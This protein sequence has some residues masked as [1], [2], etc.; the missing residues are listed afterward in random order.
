MYISRYN[1]RGSPFEISGQP[2]AE[3]L[4]AVGVGPGAKAA[5]SN[6][7]TVRATFPWIMSSKASLISSNGR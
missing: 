4:Y 7:K 6:T 5:Y 3:I 1:P 2:R